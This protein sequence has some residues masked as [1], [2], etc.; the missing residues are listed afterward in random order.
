MAFAIDRVEAAKRLGVSTRT[1]DRHIQAG[2]VRTRRIGK[3]MY[4]EDSDIE[5]L[6]MLDPSRREEDYI[7]ILDREEFIAHPETTGQEMIHVGSQQQSLIEFAR[8]YEETQI[9]IT[10]KDEAI[11][12]L[13][14]RLGK[15]EAELKNSIPLMEYKK[16]TYLLES[17]KS[18]SDEDAKNLSDTISTLEKEIIKRNSMILG[19]TI[20]FI[21]VLAFSF[22]FFLFARGFHFS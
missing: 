19:L 10:K 16:A 5:S 1:V 7:V 8:F 20:L 3:K 22:V 4:I 2:R 13:S 21:L 12:D 17:A 6:R 11:Q 18:K 9:L 14:Y 15:S